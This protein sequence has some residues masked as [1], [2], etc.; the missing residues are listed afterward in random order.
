[1]KWFFRLTALFSAVL[2]CAGC[3]AAPLPET[4][5]PVPADPA[6][7]APSQPAPQSPAL[8]EGDS[9]LLSLETEV[10][11]GM[12]LRLDAIGKQDSENGLWGVREVQVYHGD[13]L[14][15]RAT[16]PAGIQSR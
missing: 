10:D 16:R 2:L 3:G 15:H 6:E 11:G 14:L 5:A 9:V 1:M 8:P 4:D 12:A 7:T 13:T